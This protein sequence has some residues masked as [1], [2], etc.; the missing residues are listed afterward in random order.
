VRDALDA[1]ARELP[2]G[3][4]KIRLRVTDRGAVLVDASPLAPTREPVRLV[5]ASRPMPPADEFI[6]HKTTRRE[7][8]AAFAPT[9]GAFDTLLWNA[10]GELTETTIG[11]VALRIDGRWLTPPVSAGLLPGT[12]RAALLAEGRIVGSATARR[13]S[14]EGRGRGVLQQR[15]GVAGGDGVVTSAPRV[16]RIRGPET[17]VASGLTH[18]GHAASPC[19]RQTFTNNARCAHR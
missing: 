15:A 17:H 10:A 14:R 19:V 9:G 11:N 8:Y 6:H 3:V 13:R 5:L 12:Y 16:R 2:H 1:T 7:A 18:D 4:H